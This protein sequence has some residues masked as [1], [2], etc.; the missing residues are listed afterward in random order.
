MTKSNV[1]LRNVFLE[2]PLFSLCLT[3]T[4]V[5]GGYGI[6][7]K[8]PSHRAFVG[9]RMWDFGGSLG[10]AIDPK[11]TDCMA[12]LFRQC[13]FLRNKGNLPS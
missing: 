12:T 1:S 13:N 5:L 4:R 9:F 8:A 6:L 11:A 2:Q 7:V 10:V 3:C